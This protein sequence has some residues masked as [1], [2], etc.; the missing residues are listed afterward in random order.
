MFGTASCAQAPASA[1]RSAFSKQ[2]FEL[3]QGENALHAG[4][5]N[6]DGL[7]DLI[8]AS[9]EAGTVTVRLGD[10][11]GGFA[12]GTEFSVD[13]M[14]TSIDSADFDGDGMADL[15][16]AH[17]EQSTFTIAYGKGDG[18]VGNIEGHS[19]PDRISPHVHMIRVA[20]IGGDGRVDLLVDSRDSFGIFTLRNVAGSP[21]VF[22]GAPVETGGAPYLGFALG[23]IDGDGL[24][25]I[26][27]PNQRDTS[28]LLQNS[29]GGTFRIGQRLA[30]Q[31][32]FA[33]A[34]A[35]IDG[36]GATDL[37]VASDETRSGLFVFAGSGSGLF[38]TAASLELDLVSGAKNIATGDFDG[39][40]RTDIVVTAWS[41]EIVV[42]LNRAGAH[43][44]ERVIMP[45]L[46]APWSVVAADFDNDGRSEI[47]IADGLS[48][49]GVILSI[50]DQ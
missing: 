28:V 31:S 12:D 33:V 22:E 42:V 21:G 7:I 1:E 48:G 45:N 27:T 19:L 5:L 26:V 17:H 25:D 30:V 39:D 6:G 43:D 11:L 34:L 4:D 18:S 8:S 35:D 36:D 16:I 50:D 38:E 37:I 20:D 41:G 40:G 32:P 13:A 2:L 23:D 9:E 49:N 3:P 10:G 46:E 44:I 14:P 24:V 15:A 47:A 29:S